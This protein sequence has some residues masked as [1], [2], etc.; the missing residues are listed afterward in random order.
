MYSESNTIIE[1]DT[2][3]G[4][5]KIEE[6]T[7]YTS[8]DDAWDSFYRI[9]INDEEKESRCSHQKAICTLAE[10]MSSM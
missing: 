3:L 1:T 7:I 10:L 8:D 4:S 2:R 6:V 9:S 5:L